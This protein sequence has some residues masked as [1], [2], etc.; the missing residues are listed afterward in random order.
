MR[1]SVLPAL[2]VLLSA[3]GSAR[4]SAP[5]W[6]RYDALGGR[7][8]AV[9]RESARVSRDVRAMALD[10]GHG[11][12]RAV[13]RDAVRA[14]RDALVFSRQSG[15]VGN[16]IR[17]LLLDASGEQRAY[18]GLVLRA[19]EDDWTEGR[20]VARTADLLWADPFLMSPADVTRLHAAEA[21]AGQAARSAATASHAAARLRQ[22]HRAQFRYHPVST[23][24]P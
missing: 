12:P 15:A 1:L 19:L 7:L 22:T 4:G 11:R 14:K 5:L 24:S 2:I 18:L 3:C 21:Q 8:H 17:G 13:K 9:T 23:A 16:T 6:Q 20:Q 10:V